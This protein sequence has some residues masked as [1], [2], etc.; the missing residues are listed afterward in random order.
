MKRIAMT[1]VTLC[2]LVGFGTQAMAQCNHGY[3]GG[4][5]G[6][7]Y[8]GGY[9]GYGG[10]SFGGA[11]YGQGGGWGPSGSYFGNGG[12]DFQPHWHVTQTPY[13]PSTWYGNGPHDLVPHQHSQTPW[14]YQGYSNTGAGPTTS[15]YSPQ[16]YYFAPW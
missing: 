2:A 6:Y 1:L 16:P 11:G 14:S 3:G 10:Y 9:G 15:F 7:G 4:Y 13:G 8:G 5:G 12:H